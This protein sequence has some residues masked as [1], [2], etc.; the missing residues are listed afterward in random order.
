[1]PF[2]VIKW[3]LKWPERCCLLLEKDPIPLRESWMQPNASFAGWEL[4]I[5][6]VLGMWRWFRPS[7]N[8]WRH[9]GFDLSLLNQNVPL[10]FLDLEPFP[11]G[12]NIFFWMFAVPGLVTRVQRMG[13]EGAS[14]GFEYPSIH[15][16][17]WWNCRLPPF[18]II[19]FLLESLFKEWSWG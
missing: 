9:P 7:L 14:A 3:F 13:H 12:H 4:Q 11:F 10:K 1:M 19:S 17:V 5:V 6:S 18:Y 8:P 16:L 15:S 2:L